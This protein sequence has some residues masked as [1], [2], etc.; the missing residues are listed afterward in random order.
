[1]IS[2]SRYFPDKHCH[3][4]LRK[5]KVGQKFENP[6][7]P[8]HAFN[9]IAPLSMPIIPSKLKT[10]NLRNRADN[11]PVHAQ[12]PDFVNLIRPR[13]L[14]N[15]PCAPNRD[16]CPPSAV[17]RTQANDVHLRRLIRDYFSYDHADRIHNSPEKDISA[18]QPVS[19]KPAESAQVVSFPRMGG[20]HHRY[21][22]QQAA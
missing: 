18:M 2:T 5:G 12:H 8:Q 9:I 15:A 21:D 3:K 6:G 1:V 17:G 22:W 16:P 4:S 7:V 19:C 13:Q 11:F 14:S 20:L 10:L